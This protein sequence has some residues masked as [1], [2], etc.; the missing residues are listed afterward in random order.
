[1]A[2]DGLHATHTTHTELTT[3]KRQRES[4]KVGWGDL[5][6]CKWIDVMVVYLVVVYLVVVYRRDEC[7]GR[8]IVLETVCSCVWN[9]QDMLI[10]KFEKLFAHK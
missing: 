10:E 7:S 5:I 3:R 9:K 6:G 8:W 2:D 4:G 1:M